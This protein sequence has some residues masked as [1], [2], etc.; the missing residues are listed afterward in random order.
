MR[1]EQEIYNK[2]FEVKESIKVLYDFYPGEL[3]GE[4]EEEQIETLKTEE[5]AYLWV[6]G[7]LPFNNKL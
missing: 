5:L 3:R 6:L 7:L 4:V 2:L 1:T